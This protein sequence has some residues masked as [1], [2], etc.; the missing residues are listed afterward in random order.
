MIDDE[1]ILCA[2]KWKGFKSFNVVDE[3]CWRFPVLDSRCGFCNVFKQLFAGFRKDVHISMH[4]IFR[5]WES[6]FSASM[7]AGKRRKPWSKLLEA[8]VGWEGVGRK[9]MEIGWVIGQLG[10]LSPI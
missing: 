1:Q 8:A 2:L 3:Y 10:I 4:S 7:S 9:P 6:S 5:P